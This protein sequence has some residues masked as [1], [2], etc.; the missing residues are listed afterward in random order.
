[1]TV[2]LK[3]SF[4]IFTGYFF[5]E[6]LL[7]VKTPMAGFAYL[8]PNFSLFLPSACEKRTVFS[9]KDFSLATMQL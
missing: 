1:M 9:L 6:A 3:T 7:I 5:L 4:N 2:S 8:R